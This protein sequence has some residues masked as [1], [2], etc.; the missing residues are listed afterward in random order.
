[1]YGL[2]KIL[3]RDKDGSFSGSSGLH[4][5]VSKSELGWGEDRGVSDLRIPRTMV[6][7]IDGT[8]KNIEQTFPN[9][10]IYRGKTCDWKLDWNSYS[11]RGIDH[12]MMVMESLDADTEVRRLSPIGLAA[13]GYVDLINGPQDHGWC[14]GYTCQERISDFFMIVA[15]GLEYLIGLTSTNPQDMRLRLLNANSSQRI[16]SAIFYTIPQRLDVYVGGEYKI[17]TNAYRSTDGNINYNSKGDFKTFNKCPRR[18][19]TTMIEP[20]RSCTL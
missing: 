16:L 10:G 13:G 9:K 5:M 20:A 2:K 14:G 17:P 8:K 4:T 3:I 1:M 15:S 11:C 7:N 19:K 12:L 18:Y 6:A